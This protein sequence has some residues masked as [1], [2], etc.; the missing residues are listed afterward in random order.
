MEQSNNWTTFCS[1]RLLRRRFLKRETIQHKK[2]FELNNN[3]PVETKRREFEQS[4]KSM[5]DA[6]LTHR[7]ERLKEQKSNIV[8]CSSE[9]P[10]ETTSPQMKMRMTTQFEKPLLFKS[11]FKLFLNNYRISSV[12]A[13]P[14]PPQLSGCILFAP[15]RRTYHIFTKSFKHLLTRALKLGVHNVLG[16]GGGGGGTMSQENRNV[17]KKAKIFQRCIQIA[18]EFPDKKLSS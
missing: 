4:S 7:A 1:P 17:L 3:R 11:K 16:G 15:P 6:T 8:K 14:P 10:I 9:E 12:C 2:S 13:P 18:L 5:D